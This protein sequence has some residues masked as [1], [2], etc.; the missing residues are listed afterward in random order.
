MNRVVKSL[1]RSAALVVGGVIT[2]AP[3][4]AQQQKSEEG[5]LLS[6][7]A[8]TA[9]MGQFNPRGNSEAFQLFDA[10][11]SEGT[12]AL[13][14]RVT[15]GTLRVRVW[16][17]LHV[18]GSAETG[19]RTVNSFSLA[20]GASASARSAQQTRL[21]L[22]GV[23]TLGLQLQAWSWKTGPDNAPT[24]RLRLL[25]GAGAGRATYALRQWGSFVDATRLVAFN[26]DLQSK[27]SGTI[28]Y[29]TAA[30]EVPLTRWAAI[31]LDVR[32]QFGSA[33]MNGDFRTFDNLDLSGT[34]FSLGLTLSPW[35]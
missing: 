33:G 8:V 20:Q 21:E 12:S 35:R 11:L 15:G 25:A 10:A 13:T 27:G 14:P 29:V 3:L 2:A 32:Q 7:L 22:N 1:V 28:S 19:D 9:H 31:Q 4:A 23:Q 26:D 5:S 16:K 30:A 34:R 18:V 17:Q 6:R 24:E